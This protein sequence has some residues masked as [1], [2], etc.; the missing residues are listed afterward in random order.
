MS[1]ID[2]HRLHAA[3]ALIAAQ[4]R[5]GLREL[6]ALTEGHLLALASRLLRDAALAEDVVQEVFV[7]VW[8]KAAEL[9]ELRSH[10]MAWLVAS[11]RNRAIDVLRKQRP[12]VSLH[13]QDA[14]GEEH[15]HEVPDESPTPP[16]QI[17]ARQADHQLT[18]CLAEL[19][20][21][22]RRAVM[23]AYFDGL[24][25]AELAERL[26]R[27]LGTVKA[28]VRRSLDRLRLCLGDPA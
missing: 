15:Q 12:E 13:W 20:P 22:P 24:T 21:E 11:V 8:R 27:P 18:D 6:Y 2:P 9:P 25:H 10:P 1:A 23:M 5:N 28:W 14:D 26:A 17:A 3:L 16:E 4:D 19:E 7:G